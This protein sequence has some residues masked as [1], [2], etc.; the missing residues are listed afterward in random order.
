MDYELI[1]LYGFKESFFVDINND[2]KL[3]SQTCQ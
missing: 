2:G 3:V 1:I